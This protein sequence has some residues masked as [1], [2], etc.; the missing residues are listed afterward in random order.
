MS[1]LP[2]TASSHI[3]HKATRGALALL[4][5][6]AFVYGANIGGGIL[7]A[8]F[9]TPT[10]FGFYGVILFVLMFL[11][12][13]GGTGFAANLIRLPE[14][15]TVAEKQAVF[16]AQQCLVLLLCL[17]VWIISPQLAHAYHSPASGAL[18]F[19]LLALSFFLTSV[20]VIPQIQ[21]ERELAFDQLALI[22]V[23]QAVVFNASA[24]LFAWRHAGILS[25]S[26]ALA[27]RSA[28]GAV[29]ASIISPWSIGLRFDFEL[30][31]KHVRFG[32]ALQGANIVSAIKDSI[33]PVFVGM[34]LGVA[35]VGYVTWA[36][37]LAT[38]AVVALMPLQRLYLPFF[39]R[40]QEDRQE[41][42]KYVSRTLW[43]TNAIAAPATLITVALAHPIT[44]IVFGTKWLYALPLFYY[45]V[46]GNVFIACSTPMLGALNSIHRANI[47]LMMTVMW[48]ASTWLFG[49]PLTL[50]WG[51]HGYGVAIICVNLT[52]FV[53]YWIV[54]RELK[55]SPWKAY[56]PSWPIA[57]GVALV[58]QFGKLQRMQGGL[59]ELVAT[60]VLALLVYAC[61]LFLTS[62]RQMQS[63]R[64]MLFARPV[65]G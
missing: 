5:R 4:V 61:I 31:R 8:R 35:Y 7:L 32:L 30:I 47:S 1:T 18:A 51:L 11:N 44:V 2:I 36:N 23:T 21:L 50:I 25:F 54:W 15:P 42:A 17:C 49:V 33:T 52:N 9:L 45:L 59:W 40:L 3:A 28:L 20:M 27:L 63:I 16:T 19:R 55:V 10:E 39:S 24:V 62:P 6:Q 38:Y 41:L 65:A 57:V 53:L 13:F 64:R 58:L 48:M 29:L 46:V 43:L 22:E 34:Y 60:I 12:V 37:T 26:L 56:W 14:S